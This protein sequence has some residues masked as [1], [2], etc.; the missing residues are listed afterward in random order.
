MIVVSWLV[1]CIRSMYIQI[2]TIYD[3]VIYLVRFSF[4]TTLNTEEIYLITLLVLVLADY[5]KI[6]ST[7]K[8]ISGSTLLHKNLAR[9][10][11]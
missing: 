9:H 5:H 4:R 7:I 10:V 3:Q 11:Q 6:Y 2:A 1:I 8:D